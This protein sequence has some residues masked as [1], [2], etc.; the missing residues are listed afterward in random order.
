MKSDVSVLDCLVIRSSLITETARVPFERRRERHVARTKT[1]LNAGGNCVVLYR[2]VA[3][4]EAALARRIASVPFA[5]WPE[6]VPSPA[7]GRV[8]ARNQGP[9]RLAGNRALRH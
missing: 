9:S 3:E 2:S 8:P 1:R 5:S 4:A 7:G 6:A